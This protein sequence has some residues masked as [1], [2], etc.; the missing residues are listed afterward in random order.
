[1]NSIKYSFHR[2]SKLT[3]LL[4]A[5]D[6]M[7]LIFICTFIFHLVT[8]NY[9]LHNEIDEALSIHEILDSNFANNRIQSFFFVCS[10][11]SAL[12]L[13]ITIYSALTSNSHSEYGMNRHVKL[14]LRSFYAVNLAEL[15]FQSYWAYLQFLIQFTDVEV[16]YKTYWTNGHRA[17][18]YSRGLIIPL[19]RLLEP[20][21]A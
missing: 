12:F 8:I 6:F 21:L 10:F 18:L 4:K 16:L 3:F 20:N 9:L 11:L 19:M 15:F 7:F 2:A 1:M 5:L 13:A 14:V 17:I